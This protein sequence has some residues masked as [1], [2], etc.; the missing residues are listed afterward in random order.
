MIFKFLPPI[1][2]I[3]IEVNR[4]VDTG[5]I[6]RRSEKN[7]KWNKKIFKIC[8]KNAVRN[9]ENLR[10]NVEDKDFI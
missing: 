3:K 4:P 2:C 10:D 8:Q 9:F 7:F 5:G 6:V 1:I